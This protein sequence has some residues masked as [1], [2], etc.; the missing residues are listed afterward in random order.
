[1]VRFPSILNRIQELPVDVRCCSLL[2]GVILIRAPG[3]LPGVDEALPE[4]KILADGLVRDLVGGSPAIDCLDGRVV[5]KVGAE[6]TDIHQFVRD[7][8]DNAGS[9][10][11]GLDFF[12][13]AEDL[14][15]NGGN[16]F[17]GDD[18]FCHLFAFCAEDSLSNGAREDKKS[19]RQVC[20]WQMYRVFI[21]LG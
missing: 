6:L 12:K 13:C 8:L 18:S 1:M 19:Q 5:L 11:T 3:G 9:W 17:E 21:G 14:S 16:L 7:I 4:S 20:R 2:G 10:E 15:E